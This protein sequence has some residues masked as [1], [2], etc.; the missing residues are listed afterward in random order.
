VNVS[1][2]TISFNQGA[3]LERAIRSVLGQ[4]YPHI[5][6]IVVDPGSADDSRAI[7]DRYRHRL[8]AVVY[9]SDEG[10]ADGL[11]RGFA[12]AHGDIFGYVN[13]DDALLPHAVERAVAAFRAHPWA[14]VVYGHGYIV[15]ENDRLVR[16]FRSTRYTL[17]RVAYGAANVMQQATFIRSSAFYAVGGFNTENRAIWDAELLVDLALAGSRFL[18]VNEAWALFRLHEASISGQSR[19]HAARVGKPAPQIQAN[20]DR[21][22]EKILMRPPR[23]IDRIWFAYARLYHWTTDPVNVAHRV[24]EWALGATRRHRGRQTRSRGTVAS[25]SEERPGPSSSELPVASQC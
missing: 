3:F 23:P 22:T 10:P 17:W 14:D 13:A 7:I 19:E 20:R 16:R 8:A 4:S 25:G 6:Y 12:R 18:R 11:N 2:V 5:E 21:L 15:D 24:Y 1:I 9:E